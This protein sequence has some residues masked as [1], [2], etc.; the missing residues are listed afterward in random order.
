MKVRRVSLENLVV[1]HYVSGAVQS[2]AGSGKNHEQLKAKNTQH[3]A[4]VQP[5]PVALPDGPVAVRRTGD[6]GV[7][8]LR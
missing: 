6:Q 8:F 3:H 2:Y 4:S 1:A 7:P 5:R